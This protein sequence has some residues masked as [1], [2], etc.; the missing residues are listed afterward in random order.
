MFVSLGALAVAF[1][2]A[3]TF[4]EHLVRWLTLPLPPDRRDLVT[5]GVAEPFTTSLKVSLYAAFLLALPVILWQL[6]SF[7][8]PALSARVQGTIA[9]FVGFSV[10]LL[11][12]GLAFSYFIILPA[13]LG[14]LTNYDADLYNVQIRAQDYYSFAPLVVA[15]C[16]L[17]FQ[18]PIFLLALVRLGV[19]SAAKLRRNRRYGYLFS[20]IGAILLPTV[21]PITLALEAVPLMILFELSIW[22]AVVFEARWRPLTATVSPR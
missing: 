11:V 4:H 19:L 15:G 18:L 5:F 2:V 13:A 14:F 3:F 8:A 22:L 6:W 17:L 1:S 12:G 21:D 20:L 7:L 16:A 10:A 9:G